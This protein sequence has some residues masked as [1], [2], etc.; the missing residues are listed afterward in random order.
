MEDSRIV[1]LRTLIAEAIEMRNGAERLIADL[2]EQL[3]LSLANADDASV[4][5]ERLERHKKPRS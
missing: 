3:R 4:R 5:P 2:S 1:K